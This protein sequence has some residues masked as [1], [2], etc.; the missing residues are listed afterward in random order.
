MNAL[1]AR[2]VAPLA[3]AALAFA[4]C[5]P[6]ETTPAAAPDR[7]E[8]RGEIVALPSLG[9][10]EVRVR[11]EAIPDFRDDGG[12]K[13]GMEAMTMPFT[14]AEGVS[15]DGFAVGDAVSFTLE[16]DWASK[17]SPVRIAKLEKSDLIERMNLEDGAMPPP[18]PEN[19]T[20]PAP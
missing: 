18:T 6:K 10:R 5:A 11:H 15:T 19:S 13:V 9:S 8:V 12:R 7:Y 1:S 20:P 14:L 17:R 2:F 16:V 3:A 4:G